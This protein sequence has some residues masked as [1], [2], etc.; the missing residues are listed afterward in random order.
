MEKWEVVYRL[1]G[2]VVQD[3][4]ASVGLTFRLLIPDCVIPMGRN[5]INWPRQRSARNL[6]RFAATN[7]KVSLRV[8][9]SQRLLNMSP[10]QGQYANGGSNR[11]TCVEAHLAASSSRGIGVETG[12]KREQI[13]I[14]DTTN[15]DIEGNGA[16]K[17]EVDV[18]A[19]CC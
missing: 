8:F 19:R 10:D 16:L 13:D 1:H 6:D 2:L 11:R 14:T 4:H 18:E 12:V 17:S 3:R 5:D 9:G 7:I 15:V